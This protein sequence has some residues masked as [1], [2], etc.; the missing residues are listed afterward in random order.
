[1]FAGYNPE[2]AD[3]RDLVRSAIVS[4]RKLPGQNREDDGNGGGKMTNGNGNNKIEKKIM[5]TSKTRVDCIEVN[6]QSV[7]VGVNLI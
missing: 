7:G 2:F 1:M 5:W 6:E 3:L 4:A